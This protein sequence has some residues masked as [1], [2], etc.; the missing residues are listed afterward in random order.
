L[1]EL[2]RI[3]NKATAVS[4]VPAIAP[5][6]LYTIPAD[7][8]VSAAVQTYIDVVFDQPI[9]AASVTSP[10]NNSTCAVTVSVSY[11]DFAN[12]GGSA[13]VSGNTI[14]MTASPVM[15]R[16]VTLKV[17]VSGVTGANGTQ[18]NNYQSPSGFSFVTPCGSHCFYSDSAP[19]T[20]NA[21]MGSN[22]FL[23]SAG[24]NA[25]KYIILHGGAF[26]TTIY[27]PATNQTAAGPTVSN[28]PGAGAHNFQIPTGT[29]AGH[30]M[31]ILGGNAM[32]TNRYDTTS[33]GFAG[34][35]P[36]TANAGAGAM[37]FLATAGTYAG[38]YLTVLGN[39]GANVDAYNNGTNAFVAG[40][41]I[42]GHTPTTGTYG[43]R[44]DSGPSVGKFRVRIGG[45]GF[46]RE[47]TDATDSWAAGISSSCTSTLVG[48]PAFRINFGAQ[49]GSYYEICGGGAGTNLY[50]QNASSISGAVLPA[51]AN[52]GSITIPYVNNNTNNKTLVFGANA[53]T[54]TMIY[55]A[56]TNSWAL[57]PF[58]NTAMA[59]GA[60]YFTVASGS[61]ADRHFIIL[62][63]TSQRTAM[64][65]PVTG[66]FDGTRTY[67][68]PGAGSNFFAIKSGQHS[69]KT[70]IL[71]GASTTA[72]MA[73]N[74]QTGTMSGISNTAFPVSLG[75]GNFPI[76]SGIHSGKTMIIN[77][78]SINSELFDPASATF[79][80]SGIALIAVAGQGAIFFTLTYGPSAGH[81]VIF[82]GNST[83]GLE[84]YNPA[85]H[86][87]VTQTTGGSAKTNGALHFTI[88]SD[89]LFAGQQMIFAGGMNTERFD[90]SNIT[91]TIGSV[92]PGAQSTGV[93]ASYIYLTSG[94]HAGKFLI[95]HGNT[96]T[97]TT[98]FTPSTHTMAV[99]PNVGPC[100]G[101]G[102]GSQNFLIQG[103]PHK[104]K[105]MILLGGGNATNCLY[106]VATNTFSIPT[107][108]L[109][110]HSAYGATTGTLTFA[111]DGGLYPTAQVII[112]GGL[113]SVFS[114]YFGY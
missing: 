104:G 112:H 23:V 69:G 56:T 17:K 21:T 16:G 102:A 47:Y 68:T 79:S 19:L 11:N 92:I 93:G 46:A 61:L 5:N 113:H 52:A 89:G 38:Q 107:P 59:A 96:A 99:G 58:V 35:S 62:G 71:A 18:A 48:L 100:G 54:S 86:T 40:P 49:S 30:T 13:T 31:V 10:G 2:E 7:G 36:N 103:G 41:A 14:R 88:P 27:D 81:T 63:N 57:G 53:L 55:T 74:P 105:Y 60:N 72:A 85:T 84:Y 3:K 50:D 73:Y 34:S 66:D 33:N 9:D 44:L 108:T 70:L 82:R 8:T 95:I 94:P 42:A 109:G 77:G 20:A 24:T 12:C 75:G 80:N 110:P 76:T 64:F 43:Y 97:T 51:G 78:T 32:I 83:N 29:N 6:V 28:F 91:V 114:H 90:P 4:P 87:F 26:S 45:Q 67:G 111:N 101:P 106:D 15:P 39:S 98:L 22:S 25:G 1:N 37:S 65:N